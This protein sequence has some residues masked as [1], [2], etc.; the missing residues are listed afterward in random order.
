MDD[1][2]C[3]WSL[4]VNMRLWGRPCNL[5]QRS[6]R[7]NRQ[8]S[9]I[10]KERDPFIFISD[11]T[12]W[13]TMM[14]YYAMWA[15]TI[16]W[17]N[18]WSRTLTGCLDTV[19]N[20]ISLRLKRAITQKQSD[21]SDFLELDSIKQ[22]QSII[23]S[24][25]QW[26]VKLGRIDITMAVMSLCL[27]RAA[28]RKG[29]LQRARKRV[30]GYLSKLRNAVIRVRLEMPDFSMLPPHSYDWITLSSMLVLWNYYPQEMMLLY[31]WATLCY[32]QHV[33]R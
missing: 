30:V 28:P 20:L 7:H 9:S 22:Y 29:Y 12:T 4:R 17:L 18:G 2:T 25:H 16:N 14:I 26:A 24:L 6:T 13:E 1:A 31:R 19:H 3:W 33:W 8:A 21:D 27:F 32:T 5:F 23:G 11:V 10:S 15:K